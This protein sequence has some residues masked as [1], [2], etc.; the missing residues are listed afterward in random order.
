VQS[1][2]LTRSLASPNG[3]ILD[4]ESAG[5]TITRNVLLT[6]EI[7][8]RPYVRIYRTCSESYPESIYADN[9]QIIFEGEIIRPYSFIM[10]LFY[11]AKN[12]II[13]IDRYADK[14]LLDMLYNIKVNTTIY[15]SI[16]ALIN[17]EVIKDNIRIINT[18]LIHDRII[19]IDE[20]SYILG[21]SINSIGK[22]RFFI[23]KMEDIKVET[24]LKG[25]E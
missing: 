22:K 9:N 3:I 24:I 6:E 20:V 18:E 12:R 19:T 14:L 25:I 21:T 2:Y 23:L 4:W 1:E 11:L 16:D 10:K 5:T 15:T 8:S 13:I 7:Q 17:K